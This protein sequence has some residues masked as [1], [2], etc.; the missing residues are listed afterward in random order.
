[1]ETTHEA[2]LR[3]RVAG[4][5]AI[6]RCLDLVLTLAAL[7]FLAPLLLGLALLVKAASHGSPIF[8]QQRIGKDGVPFTMFKF[9]T[10]I[11]NSQPYAPHPAR[12]C[13]PRITPIGR[14]LRRTNLDELPQVVNV[15]QGTMSLV[16]PRPEMEF[17]TA[18]YTDR[19]RLRLLATPGITGLWQISPHR[20][21]PIHDH[22]EEDLRYIATMGPALDLS[23]LARTLA[24]FLSG[25]N[26]DKP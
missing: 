16:G 3:S 25:T 23:I 8:R 20:G 21:K 5:A 26:G 22:V 6:K 2:A 9:R 10:L 11:A 18:T 19:Q 1:V 14:F 12:P 15:L 7:P 4:Y 24:R 17:I 13:D